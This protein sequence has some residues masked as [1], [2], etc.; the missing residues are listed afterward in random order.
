MWP[1]L[2][3]QSN[4]A[5]LDRA[6][7]KQMSRGSAVPVIL[8][9]RGPRNRLVADLHR[10][11]IRNLRE[12]PIAHGVAASLTPAWIDR[13]ASDPNVERI[14]FD[15]PVRLSDT[16]VDAS[17]LASVYP[18]AVD[19]IPAWT[20]LAGPLAG[21]GI[22]VA[23]IDSGVA[24]HPDL[25]GRVV[26]NVN[27][28]PNVNDAGDAYGHGTA[29]AGVLGGN[30]AASGGQFIGIAP[31]VNVI[32]LRVNDGTGA[33]PTSAIMNAI[34]WA[35]LNRDTYNIRVINLSLQAS[36]A[37]SYQTS[38]LDAAVEYA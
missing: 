9:A 28:N 27:F 33:A 38:P 24:Q 36:I 17:S 10:N 14:A 16:L 18:Y 34:L 12:V 8:V 32:N 11:G 23:V 37:E 29:V 7:I 31:Q 15:A 19:A 1:A 26:V 35:V 22:G 21:Q 5:H 6:V 2:A 3:S 20:R 13:L 4:R 30:G 25:A